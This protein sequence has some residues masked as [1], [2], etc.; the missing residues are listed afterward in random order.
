MIGKKQF[1]Y[2]SDSPSAVIV[3]Q[4]YPPDGWV[5]TTG[6]LLSINSTYGEFEVELEVQFASRKA[7]KLMADALLELL[8][9][10][11]QDISMKV[12]WADN[13]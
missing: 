10:E 3:S 11:K 5:D 8:N 4:F 9:T 12:F 13:Y 7:V 6:Y 1:F 2:L